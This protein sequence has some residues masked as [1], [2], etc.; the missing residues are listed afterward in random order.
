MKR[1]RW[2]AGPC[3]LSPGSQVS[4]APLLPSLAGCPGR[5]GRAHVEVVGGL[6]LVVDARGAVAVIMEEHGGAVV[7]LQDVHDTAT[8]PVI[9]DTA[10]VVDLPSCVL[11]D[12]RGG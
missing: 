10:P 12:L 11:E 6:D 5:G 9:R 4:V 8:V 7:V 3:L 1:S 2:R